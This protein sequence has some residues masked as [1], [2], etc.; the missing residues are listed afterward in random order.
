[1]ALKLLHRSLPNGFSSLI[2]FICN[3]SKSNLAIKCTECDG[4]KYII[5]SEEKAK[6]RARKREEEEKTQPNE[7]YT[8][9]YK[10]SEKYVTFQFQRIVLCRFFFV[11]FSL[12]LFFHLYYFLFVFIFLEHFS[13]FFDMFQTITFCNLKCVEQFEMFFFCFL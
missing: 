12:F 3:E 7:W 2:L 5:K 6:R 8:N 11:D 10:S 4:H 9:I 13:S 1:M